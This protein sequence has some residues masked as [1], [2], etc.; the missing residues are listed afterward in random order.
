MY[1]IELTDVELYEI[2]AALEN[3][4]DRIDEDA[5]GDATAQRLAHIVTQRLAL[6][7]RVLQD[8]LTKPTIN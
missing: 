2:I 5:V 1:Q 7:L 3:E 4:I 8:A 6:H